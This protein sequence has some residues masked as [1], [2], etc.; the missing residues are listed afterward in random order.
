M[1]VVS[2]PY[3]VCSSSPSR[4]VLARFSYLDRVPDIPV[5]PQQFLNKVVDACAHGSDSARQLFTDKVVDI[6]V[7]ALRSGGASDSVIDT[8]WRPGWALFVA[9]CAIFRTLPRGL[10]PGVR[11]F[12]RALDDE[13]FF[14]IEGS[15]GW[16]GRRESD[17]QVTCHM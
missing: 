11:G 17:S 9:F 2:V 4:T 13:E 10:S 15:P 5:V 16:R 12:F 14:V 7:L 1:D 3:S 8:I 6:P